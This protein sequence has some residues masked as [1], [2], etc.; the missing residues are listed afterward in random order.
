VRP[1]SPYAVQKYTNEMNAV[2]YYDLYGLETVCLRYFNVFG[3]RQD[4]T[5]PYSGVISIFMASAAQG[6]QPVI[7]GDGGQYRDFVFVNDVVNANLLA[8]TAD[9]A[10]GGVFNIGTG[11]CVTINALWNKISTMVGIDLRPLYE[12]PRAGDIL[13]SVADIGRARAALG[14]EADYAFDDGLRLTYEWFR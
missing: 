3:P 6:R 2:L 10:R 12:D 8:A 14:Y 1:Q 5:S 11:Q 9:K 7:Y 4:P 13:E